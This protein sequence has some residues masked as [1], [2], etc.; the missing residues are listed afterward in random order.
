MSTTTT[1]TVSLPSGLPELRPSRSDAT[2]AERARSLRASI[3]AAVRDFGAVLVRG[4]DVSD[5]DTA[6]EVGRALI[7]RPMIEREPFA[8][9]V[10]KGG[11]LYSSSEWPAD[12]PLC[13]HHELSYLSEVP[14]RIVF[15]CL[16][17]PAAGGSTGL[18]DAGQVLRLLPAGL[19]D[20]AARHGW[21][22]T[23]SY[24]PALGMSW[25]QAFGTDDRAELVRLCA[26]E[27]ITLTWPAETVLHTSRVRP[28]VVAHP[29]SGVQLWFNQLAF[30]SSATMDPVIRD[31]LLFEFGPDGLP[32]DTALGD[33]SPLGAE[34][35][36]AINRAYDG[37]TLAE[38]WRDGDVLVVDN[39]RM[40]HSRA[41]FEGAREVVLMLGNP[42]R[43]DPGLSAGQGSPPAEPG[44]GIIR[45]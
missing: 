13:M 36:Q 3:D 29:Q 9:R 40:A 38:P 20:R 26:R 39:L 32:F 23:R 35:V 43:I 10:D 11:G 30:L 19:R 14:S 8:P 7:D 44:L 22:L 28:A 34:L 37:C 21:L 12:S 4:L 31:Y 41:P 5:H 24:N 6:R 15:S 45:N 33:G 27:R 16:R 18:A 17:A 1:S 2:A 25:Q 42:V